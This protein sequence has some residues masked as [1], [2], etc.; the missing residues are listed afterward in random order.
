MKKITACLLCVIVLFSMCSCDISH[1][2]NL[3]PTATIS[4]NNEY[5]I[6]T[7]IDHCAVEPDDKLHMTDEDE[8][9]Y[10]KLMDAM[11]SQEDS[12]KLS[13]DSSKNEY[14]IDLLKQSPYFFFVKKYEMNKNKV[15]F[16]YKYAFHILLPFGK[17]Q[18]SHFDF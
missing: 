11:L 6:I 8:E 3:E 10:R 7:Q 12:V 15:I 1:L 14:Y 18:K 16:T 2:D 13:D 5:M 4:E 17:Q 9:F